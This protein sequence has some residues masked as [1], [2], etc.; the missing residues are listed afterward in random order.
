[1]CSYKTKK[2]TGQVMAFE[3]MYTTPVASIRQM[4]ISCPDAAV[5]DLLI[6]A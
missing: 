4:N 1:M 3:E 6:H 2:T 5:L